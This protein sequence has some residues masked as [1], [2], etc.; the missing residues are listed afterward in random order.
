M[1]RY[2]GYCQR[3]SQADSLLVGFD[4]R[5]DV[6]EEGR[7]LESIID[8]LTIRPDDYLLRAVCSSLSSGVR[9]E[10]EVNFL[11]ARPRISGRASA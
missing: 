8:L 3:S 1:M 5:Y 7:L 4:A 9:M 2:S 11:E 6:T 10:S